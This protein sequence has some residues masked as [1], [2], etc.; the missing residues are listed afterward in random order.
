[1]NT[2]I[3]SKSLR[4]VFAA[5]VLGAVAAGIATP[6][7]AGDYTEVRSITVQ[8]GDL[9]L[10]NPLGAA[11]LYGRI[12]GA[13]HEVCDLDD[14]NLTARASERACVEKAV[15]DAVTKVGHPELFAVYSA[16][17]HRASPMTVAS[18]R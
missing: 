14:D 15:A 7:I 2:M 18:A 12:V 10:S 1:M 9:N 3:T 8:Y 13:A 11:T 5:A 4:V 16:K 6:G 17:T